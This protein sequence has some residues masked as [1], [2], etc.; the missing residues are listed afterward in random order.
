MLL[1]Q[2]PL[3]LLLLWLLLCSSD[4]ASSSPSSPSIV[5]TIAAPAPPPTSSNV[6][7]R[8][9]RGKYPRL[10]VF[11][12]PIIVP[13][14]SSSS[15]SSSLPLSV[16]AVFRHF[17]YSDTQRQALLQRYPFLSQL[18]V[19]DHLYPKLAFLRSD[20]VM[21][22]VHPA[23][24]YTALLEHGKAFWGLD[25]LSVVTRH[26][27][28]SYLCQQQQ[29]HS[30]TCNFLLTSEKEASSGGCRNNWLF[31]T[32]CQ[33]DEEH[34]HDTCSKMLVSHSNEHPL[35][36]KMSEGY[37]DFRKRFIQGGLQ[38]VRNQDIKL[39]ELL[40]SHGYHPD[41]DLDRNNRSVLM[42]ACALGK[43]EQGLP[44]VQLL[45]RFYQAKKESCLQ[46]RSVDGDSIMHYAAMGGSLDICKYLHE[47]WSC[48]VEVRNHDENHPLHWAAG[49]GSLDIVRW[50]VE[51]LGVSTT[52]SNR[53][54]CHPSHFAASA[55]HLPVCQ[56]L[57]S[58]G[59]DL[60]FCN[61]HGHDALTKAVAL[62]RNQVLKWLLE[63]LP[64]SDLYVRLLRP[65][66]EDTHQS[67]HHEVQDKGEMRTLLDIAELVGNQEAV[68]IL[69]PYF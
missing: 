69:Q 63:V 44:I 15:S 11:S 22:Y 13:S 9:R 27:Y 32:F 57:L 59:V 18:D 29:Q 33:L 36:S 24:Q 45:C 48:P 40:L 65:W 64:Q 55:G 26:A 38:A 17:Q 62:K 30:Q 5:G 56:Y 4:A 60:T 51:D 66:N 20:A 41:E 43:L 58:K 42:W 10:T 31:P 21:S 46:H 1:L 39:L 34:F 16:D 8:S 23:E 3:L 6:M 25:I 37:I 67:K 28:L 35:Q 68:E 12:K 61:F 14:S 54:G 47:E 53:F 50:L 49:S 7:Q 52:V 2:Q 19:E